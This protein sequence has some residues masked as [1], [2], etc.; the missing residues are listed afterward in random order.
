MK[1]ENNISNEN[2]NSD[3]GTSDAM[4]QNCEADAQQ[5]GDNGSGKPHVQH[6]PYWYTSIYC[7]GMVIVAKILGFLFKGMTPKSDSKAEILAKAMKKIAMDDDSGMLGSLAD[8]VDP[9]AVA[10]S[11]KAVTDLA[12][13]SAALDTTS[14]SIS[15]LLNIL[16]SLDCYAG[17]AFC[18]CMTATFI[19]CIIKRVQMKR[20]TFKREDFLD[21]Y[22]YYNSYKIRPEYKRLICNNIIV[23]VAFFY[24]WFGFIGIVVGGIIYA[25]SCGIDYLFMLPFIRDK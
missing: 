20:G 8:K 1:N 19:F 16:F 11:A 13:N 24:A 10:N 12:S 18:I 14:A 6:S 4:V 23:M 3:V 9:N 25:L 15:P 7:L 17:F 2:L 5:N 22:Y 21:E